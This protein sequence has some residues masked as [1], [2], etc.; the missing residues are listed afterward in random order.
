MN[1]EVL[2]V[3]S[4]KGVIAYQRCSFENQ[5]GSIAVQLQQ[6]KQL[7]RRRYNY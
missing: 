6:Q 2:S 3:E 4:Q 1:I 5:K 7:Q